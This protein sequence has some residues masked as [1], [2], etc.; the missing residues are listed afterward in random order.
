MW[1]SV[2]LLGSQCL[3]LCLSASLRRLPSLLGH[4]LTR[5][6]LSP[7]PNPHQ[8]SPGLT[9]GIG[10]QLL[11]SLGTPLLSTAGDA[12]AVL[13][14]SCGPSDPVQERASCPPLVPLAVVLQP[15]GEVSIH[16]ERLCPGSG[17]LTCSRLCLNCYLVFFLPLLPGSLPGFVGVRSPLKLCS[18]H[19]GSA[20]Q[21]PVSCVRAA[22]CTL[23]AVCWPR[24]GAGVARCV[25]WINVGQLYPVFW[26]RMAAEGQTQGRDGAGFVQL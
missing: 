17:P 8:A 5:A 2:G 12:C 1:G 14:L 3:R 18:L 13:S 10:L 16:Q 24:T 26:A 7:P 20:A 22:L 6:M 11:V 23:A 4:P 9:L 15:A 21:P 25:G 19:A